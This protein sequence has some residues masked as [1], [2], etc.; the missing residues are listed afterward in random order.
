MSE[1]KT[2]F[3]DGTDPK[4]AA[5]LEQLRQEHRVTRI[6]LTYGDPLTGKARFDENEV[7]GYVGRSTG[8]KPVL[9]LVC[10]R[11]SMGGGLILSEN[12]VRIITTA[13][14]LLYQHPTYVAPNLA[15][16]GC[17]VFIDGELYANFENEAK[18]KRWFKKHTK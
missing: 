14:T 18:A 15:L 10:N 1:K 13:G 5:I 4:V 12:I 7:E 3:H 11:R 6:R 2:H 17:D 16:V 8:N 9:L